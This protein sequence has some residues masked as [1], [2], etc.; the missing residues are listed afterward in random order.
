[1]H[2]NQSPIQRLAAA[3]TRWSTRYVPDAFVIAISLTGLVGIAAWALTPSSPVK[4]LMAWGNG[5]WQL[6]EFASQMSL[7]LLGGYVLAQAPVVRRALTALAGLPTTARQAIAMTAGV[8]MGLALVNW[9]LSI[10]GSAFLVRAVARGNVKVDHRLLCATGYL[11]LGCVWHA[12][13]SASAPLL[14]ATQGKYTEYFGIIPISDT[15]LLPLNIA[16][17]VICCLVFPLLTAA[18]HPGPGQPMTTADP[19]LL[20]ETQPPP[21]AAGTTPAERLE[22]SAWL[23]VGTAAL[24]LGAVIQKTADSGFAAIHINTVNLTMLALGLALHRTPRAFLSACSSAG[25]GMWPIILQFPF[26]AG[27]LGI[28][29]GSGLNTV[30]AQGFA[31]VTGQQTFPLFVMWYSGLLNY[32]VPSGGSKLAIEASYIAAASRDLGVPMNVTVM[33][34]AWGDML[35]DIIQPFWALPLLAAAK[36]G[37]RDIMGYCLII[38]AVFAAIVSSGFGLYAVG[39]LSY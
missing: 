24:A 7:M 21:A 16:L 14:V 11:G 36:L 26:Y 10:V 33:A 28:I 9:A 19:A 15:L 12:G 29:D 4:L 31:S 30:L 1:M 23:G 2:S 20:V 3:L 32:V 8:S 27:I 25:E 13:L 38:F 17:V 34:Y 35:T 5:L 22:G 6:L 37:F 18:M 39:I